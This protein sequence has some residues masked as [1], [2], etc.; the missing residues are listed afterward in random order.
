MN[1]LGLTHMNLG[2][3]DAALNW[4][5]RALSVVEHLDNPREHGKPSFA[6]VFCMETAAG[7][8]GDNSESTDESGEGFLAPP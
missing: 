3:M 8:K 5:E 6:A 7:D 4:F 2:Q 1:R